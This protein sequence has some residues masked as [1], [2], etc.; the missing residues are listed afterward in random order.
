MR[1]TKPHIEELPRHEKGAIQRQTTAYVLGCFRA[2][3]ATCRVRRHPHAREV[4]S[5]FREFT[6][7]F[8]PWAPIPRCASICE[9]MYSEHR[10]VADTDPAVARAQIVCAQVRRQHDRTTRPVHHT[11]KRTHELRREYGLLGRCVRTTIRKL[12][13][14]IARDTL[15]PQ[16]ALRDH[17][18]SAR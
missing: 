8:C 4:G 1:V 15:T 7:A 3:A 12:L 10:L 16:R 11:R 13:T 18:A 14:R 17:R 2:T 5:R 6:T 9:L